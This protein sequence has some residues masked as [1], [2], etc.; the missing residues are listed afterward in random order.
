MDWAGCF[1]WVSMGFA[2]GL[3]RRGA[4]VIW[5]QSPSWKKVHESGK[6]ARPKEHSLWGFN[7]G[8]RPRV[9]QVA[10]ENY[11]RERRVGKRFGA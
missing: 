2:Q 8:N 3:R 9:R 10:M 11:G 6:V 1:W 5:G 4:C 7:E